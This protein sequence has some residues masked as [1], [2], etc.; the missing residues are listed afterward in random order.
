MRVSDLQGVL[1]CR[2]CVSMHVFQLPAGGG[3]DVGW[4]NAD[5]PVRVEP[6]VCEPCNKNEPLACEP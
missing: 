2:V 4:W 6:P 3:V 5:A 1:C